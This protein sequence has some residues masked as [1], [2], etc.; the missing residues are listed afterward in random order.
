MKF[1]VVKLFILQSN[2]DARNHVDLFLAKYLGEWN[3]DVKFL[4]LDLNLKSP[5]YIF[6]QINKNGC[7][8]FY[9][10]PKEWWDL[11]FGGTNEMDFVL[12]FIIR[13]GPKKHVD[14][15]NQTNENGLELG[16]N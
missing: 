8:E 7:E 4:L 13:F 10:G 5:I 2:L 14:F 6:D 9:N 1:W 3:G 16:C 12:H 11:I 15:F